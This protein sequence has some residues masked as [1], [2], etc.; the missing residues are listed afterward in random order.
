VPFG[1]H[2]GDCADYHGW[3]VGIST[4]DPTQVVAW[5]TR[6]LAGGVWAPGGISTDGQSMYFATGNTEN[7]A[8]TFTAPVDWQDGETVFKLPPSLVFS[9]QKADYFTPSN[10]AALD[11]SDSDIGGSG[12]IL[13][14]VPGATPSE[15]AIGLGKDGN[16]YLLD[17]N[18]LGGISSP[19][20]RAQ[21]A[22]GS[23]I[24]AAAAYT[25]PKGSYVVFK[26]AGQ[27]C[28]A[29]QSG[30]LAAF[31]ISAASPPAV[32]MAWCGGPS[33]QDSPAVSATD[34]QGTDAL[35]WIVGSDNKLYALDGETGKAVF[36]GGAAADTMSAVQ[37]FVT[38]IV[39]NGRVFVAANNQVYAFTP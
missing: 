32:S 3:I 10:W 19:P 15:L 33:T 13:F 36:S 30:G 7:Q 26:G 5:S 2:I 24:N 4:Q 11:Q 35:V 29:G 20:T 23:I 34:A 18:N 21:V 38:P 25:T 16:A 27:G 12:P 37:K 14:T 28:P 31:K 22:T 9:G 6:A 1:V 39:A 8:N 17:R